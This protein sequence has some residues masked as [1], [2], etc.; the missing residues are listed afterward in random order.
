MQALLFA[1]RR[2]WLLGAAGLATSS[3]QAW[4]TTVP[5]VPVLAYHRFGEQAVDS[6]TIR[7]STFDAHLA[8]L[9]DLRCQVVPM[10]ALIDWL[11]RGQPLPDRAVVLTADDGHRSQFEHMAPRLRSFAWEVT[12]FIYPSAIS[13]ASYAM[14]WDQ[15]RSLQADGF[16]VESHTFWHPNFAQERR[17]L[18]PASYERFAR[19]QLQRS[20]ERLQRELDRPVRLLAW[21]FGVSEPLVQQIAHDTGYEAAFSL[22]NRP[23]LRSDDRFVLP[24]YLVTEA[25]GATQLRHLL[26][27][28]FG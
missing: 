8:V 4:G 26:M 13:N 28:S 12:L 24:R 20:R 23:T 11:T 14:T 17:R 16:R 9:Q 3:W 10:Q 19:D 15:L 7:L 5:A 1:N 18:D 21:P 2:R 27:A 6:M 25:M 22:G